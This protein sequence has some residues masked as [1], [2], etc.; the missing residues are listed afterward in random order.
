MSIGKYELR[1]SLIKADNY[2]STNS[3]KLKPNK[4]RPRVNKDN[5]II[6]NGKTYITSQGHVSHG[7][8]SYH[9]YIQGEGL[10]DSY[11]QEKNSPN[12]FTK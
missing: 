7:P 9:H 10:M 6:V 4:S 3:R 8:E 11:F 2:K 12:T 5:T 1:S